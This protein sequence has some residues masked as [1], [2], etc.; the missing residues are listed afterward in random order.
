MCLMLCAPLDWK[1]TELPSIMYHSKTQ[2]AT[3]SFYIQR[4][5][6]DG[7]SLDTTLLQW[8]YYLNAINECGYNRM[9]HKFLRIWGEIAKLNFAECE[10]SN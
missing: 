10:L 5:D 3:T 6:K 7:F 8:Y 9:R 2:K 1:Y 4:Y